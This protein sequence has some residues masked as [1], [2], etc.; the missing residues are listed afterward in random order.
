MKQCFKC[1]EFRELDCFYKHPGMKDGHLN[2]CIECSKKDAS[3]NLKKIMADPV[4]ADKER[5]RLL[6]KDRRLYRK[7]TKPL[8]ERLPKIHKETWRNFYEKYPE[9]YHAAIAADTLRPLIRGNQL[10]HWSYKIE[11][12]KDVIELTKDGHYI[13]H[14]YIFY[15]QLEM[16]YR[17]LDSELLDTKEKHIAHLQILGIEIVQHESAIK[18]PF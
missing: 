4:L 15:D 17:N 12:A 14:K 13:A 2:K 5:Q 18:T 8:R 11:N 3:D 9:K 16:A 7:T 6:E 10:H 1:G